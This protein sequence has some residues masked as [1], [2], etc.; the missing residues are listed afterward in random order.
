MVGFQMVWTGVPTIWKPDHSKVD[1]QKVRFSN[2]SGFR[3]VG[4]QIPTVFR[5]PLHF[6]YDVIIKILPV[7]W[8]SGPGHRMRSSRRDLM[9]WNSI[10]KS[11]FLRCNDRRV[12]MTQSTLTHRVDPPRVHGTVLS[13]Q[14]LKIIWILDSQKILKSRFFSVQILN[15]K[16]KSHD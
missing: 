11:Y 15:G 16:L 14:S 9:N 6:S 5:F 4:F 2:D 3:M 12:S 1:L 13:L 10:E 7:R 8:Q